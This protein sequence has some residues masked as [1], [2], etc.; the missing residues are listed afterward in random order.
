MSNTKKYL[1]GMFDDDDVL[2]HAIKNIRK[3][4]FKITDCFT[5]FPVH[6]I[7]SAMSIEPTRLHTAG[8]MFGATGMS[9]ALGV[10]TFINAFDYPTIFGG[11]PYWALMAYV[12]IVFEHTVLYSAVGMVIAFYYLCKLYPGKKPIIIDER[13]TDHLF[14][15]TFEMDGSQDTAAISD[16]LKKEG[17]IEVYQKEV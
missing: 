10:I 16:L 1:V 2:L 13:T 8:F 5:P 6:G 7:E 15:L 12:P 4:G 3:E 11:K 14:A 9:V 17:A